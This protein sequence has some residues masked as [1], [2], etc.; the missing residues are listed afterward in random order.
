MY[1]F[2]LGKYGYRKSFCVRFQAEIPISR[3]STAY[4]VG[5]N[6]HGFVRPESNEKHLRCRLSILST[7]FLWGTNRS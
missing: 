2:Q 7:S 6:G 3:S 1:Y 4:Q 5:S